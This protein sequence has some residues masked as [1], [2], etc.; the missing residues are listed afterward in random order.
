MTNEKFNRLFDGPP[1]K[2]ESGLTKRE[3]DLAASI[4]VVTEEILLKMARYARAIGGK[5]HLCL[6]GGVA[7]NCVA[8]GKVLRDGKLTAI[9]VDATAGIDLGLP[10]ERKMVAEL[11]RR[12]VCEEARSSHAARDRQLGHRRLHHRLA[13]AARAGGSDVANDLEAAG[14]VLQH[15]SHALADLAQLGAAAGFAHVGRRMHD[16]AARQLGR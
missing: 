10:I 6:A 9:D 13:F 5:P 2:P 16:V 8:N 4:Q 14:Y 1:R 12:D 11:G 7:L 3:M 15:L